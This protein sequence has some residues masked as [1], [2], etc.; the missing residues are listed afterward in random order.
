DQGGPGVVADGHVEARDG[1]QGLPHARAGGAQRP[2]GV[3]APAVKVA[4]FGERE[5]VPL[6]G[7]DAGDAGEVGEALGWGALVEWPLPNAAGGVEEDADLGAGAA[8][9]AARRDLGGGSVEFGERDGDGAG[10]GAFAAV[11]AVLVDAEGDV[12]LPCRVVHERV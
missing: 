1:L 6:A 11:D 9:A 8:G 3:V 7:G 12:L 10:V 2:A 4:G 5:R